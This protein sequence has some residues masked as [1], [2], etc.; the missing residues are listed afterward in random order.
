[1]KKIVLAV[2]ILLM[3]SA[4][5]PTNFHG[6]NG[7]AWSFSAVGRNGAGVQIV[8]RNGGGVVGRN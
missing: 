7:G 6:G 4:W 5:G 8:G 2:L 1:M 3:A